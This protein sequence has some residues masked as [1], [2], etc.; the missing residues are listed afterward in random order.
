MFPIIYHAN[1]PSVLVDIHHLNVI[2]CI[3]VFA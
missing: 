2:G 3:R 1:H